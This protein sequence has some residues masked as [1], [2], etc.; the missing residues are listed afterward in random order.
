VRREVE[1]RDY[2][3]RHTSYGA[4]PFSTAAHGWPIADC[5]AEGLKVRIVKR[6]AIEEGVAR[7]Q[8]G[9]AF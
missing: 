5:T 3:Y 4:W 8:F 2:Y 1:N 6:T 9:I 7:R